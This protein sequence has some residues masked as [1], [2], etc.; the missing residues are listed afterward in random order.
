MIKHKISTTWDTGISAEMT[1]TF[2][3]TGRFCLIAVSQGHFG[4]TANV[5]CT[6]QDGIRMRVPENIAIG[7]T[8]TNMLRVLVECMD[9]A[10]V[11]LD[12]LSSIED[13]QAALQTLKDH[14][15]FSWQADALQVIKSESETCQVID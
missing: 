6:K 4:L 15:D 7:S 8:G 9:W 13:D 2:R 1:F 12:A 5:S 14:L 11:L 10:R 3:P